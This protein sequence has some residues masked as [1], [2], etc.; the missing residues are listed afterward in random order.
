MCRG[1]EILFSFLRVL[2]FLCS[3]FSCCAFM[4]P[5]AGPVMPRQVS[6]D[7][8]PP[9]LRLDLNLDLAALE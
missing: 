9:S 1:G 6:E 3:P 2:Y 4:E 5:N 8:P 7:T